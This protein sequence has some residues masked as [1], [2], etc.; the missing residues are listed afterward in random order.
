MDVKYK[1][2]QDSVEAKNL[3]IL[4][5]PTSEMIADSLTKPLRSMLL[6]KFTE[7]MGLQHIHN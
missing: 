2:L 3:E 4:F 1:Y 5:C 6:S 7:M